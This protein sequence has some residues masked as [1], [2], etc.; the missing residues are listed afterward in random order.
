MFAGIGYFTLGIAKTK[1]PARV[2]SI[3]W[4][5]ESFS[6]LQQNIKL[7]HVESIVNP[8]LGDCKEQVPI[9]VNQGILADRIIMGLIPAPV[10]AIPVA[11]GA[12]KPS[13]SIIVYEGVEPKESTAL[14]DEFQT[15]ASGL[16]IS[17]SIVERRIVKAF[18]PHE[19]HVVIEILAQPN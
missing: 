8:I 15:I 16:N 17:T 9:L 12:I 18:K 10:D 14:F 3:E 6:Y 1:K 7:N 13:G 19:Y 11:L 2:Y 4:N 5:P